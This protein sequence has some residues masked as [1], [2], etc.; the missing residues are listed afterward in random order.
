M[1]TFLDRMLKKMKMSI[2]L[3]F[4]GNSLTVFLLKNQKPQNKCFWAKN[5]KKNKFFFSQY[6]KQ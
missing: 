1:K 3:M 4:E 5:I 6:E 2:K